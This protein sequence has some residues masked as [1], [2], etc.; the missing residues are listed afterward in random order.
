MEEARTNVTSVNR[1]DALAD[2]S[3]EADTAVIVDID[4]F[5]SQLFNWYRRQTPKQN[6]LPLIPT[7]QDLSA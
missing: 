2:T 7:V 3:E 5:Y 6:A 1:T 4:L